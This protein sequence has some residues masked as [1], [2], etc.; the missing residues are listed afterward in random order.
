MVE[1]DEHESRSIPIKGQINVSVKIIA[2]ISSG[3]YRTPAGALKE[4]ISNSFDAAADT[5]IITTN[6]PKF[7]FFTIS[8][9]GSGMNSDEFE[10]IMSRIG[11]SDKRTSEGDTPGF[12]IMGRPIIGKIGIGL[13]AV[14]QICRKFTVISSTIDKAERF[15]ATIDLNQFHDEDAY[16]KH[17]YGEGVTIGKYDLY[18]EIEEQ[19]NTSYTRIILEEMHEGF[20]NRLLD[21]TN[22]RFKGR[23]GF[24]ALD[25]NQRTAEELV[26]WMENRKLK[27]Q[28]EYTKL[29]WELAIVCPVPYLEEGPVLKS[30]TIEPIA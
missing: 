23:N 19:V 21:S 3:I 7:D 9:N 4:L 16:K 15:E 8:D 2:A 28:S 5:V 1:Q 10:K 25:P 27:D 30:K 20:T 11:G 29:I 26:R 24:E 6:Y 17:F 12:N 22:K 13:L 18:T 14:A